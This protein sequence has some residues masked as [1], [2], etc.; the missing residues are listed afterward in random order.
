LIK[1][2]QHAAASDVKTVVI[3]DQILLNIETSS[4]VILPYGKGTLL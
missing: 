3:M 2:L 1:T 4:I